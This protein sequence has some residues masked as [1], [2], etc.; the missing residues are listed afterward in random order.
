MSDF[1]VNDIVELLHEGKPTGIRGTVS[2]VGEEIGFT[3]KLAVRFPFE[4]TPPGYAAWIKPDHL[5]RV[6]PEFIVQPGDVIEYEHE[7]CLADYSIGRRPTG[8]IIRVWRKTSPTTME[9]VWER[10]DE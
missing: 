4:D 10:G 8:G 3:G 5:R 9:V 7:I 2:R 6:E 1:S